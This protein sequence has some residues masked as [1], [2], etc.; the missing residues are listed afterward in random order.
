VTAADPAGTR[1]VPPSQEL[2]SGVDALVRLLVLRQELDQRDGLTTATMV[3][4]Y[5]GSP[6]G[7]LDLALEQA[8]AS[9]GAHRI[10]H[11]PGLNEELAA[12]TVWG[13]QMGEAV[14]YDG[15]DGVVGAWYGKTPGLDRSGDVMKHA[16]AMGA[17]PNGGVV[18]L[19]G[20][21]PTAKSSTLPCD[22]Q[23]TFQDAAMPVLYPGNPQEVVDL[24]IH[25]FRL[26]RY[27]G[28]WVGLKVVTAVADGIGTVDLD[29]DR[30]G[31]PALPEVRIGGSVWRHAPQRTLGPH[32]VAGQEALVHEHRLAAAEAYVVHNG[33][34]RVVGA[35]PGA[36]LGIVAAGKTAHD[37]RQA[38]ADLGVGHDGLEAAGIRV[39][40][41]AM[42]YPVAT[43]TVLDFAATVD[44]LLVVEEKRPF[45]ETQLRS[46]LHEAGRTVPVRGKRDGAGQPLVSSV[47][48]LVPAAIATVIGRV[49]PDLA[50]APVRRTLLPILDL[51]PR[52]PG[53]CS[54]CPHNRSTL[55][56]DG[57]L[58]G[59]G[60]GC[61]GIMYFEARNQGMRSLPPTPMGAE[62][63]PW[64]GLSPFVDEP[65]L[66]QNIGDGTLS[67]SGTLAIRA[68]VAAGVDITFKVLY[69]RAVA[70]TGGQDVT[71]LLDVPSM[72]RALEAEGVAKVVVCAEEPGRYPA[73]ARWAA[74]VEVFGRDHL[75]VVQ[76]QLRSVPGVSVIIYDQRCAAEARR[77][78]S[79]GELDEPP[80]RVLINH[81]VCEGCGD[82]GSKSNC[83]SVLPVATELGEKREIHDASCNRDYTCLDGDCPSF[84]TLRPDPRGRRRAASAAAATARP[85]LPD[86][87]LPA[88]ERP[89]VDPQY[90]IYVTGIG[91]T[92]I[93][94][95]NRIVATAAELG[96]LSIGGMDQTGLSQKAGAV[97]SHLHLAADPAHLGSAVVSDGGADLYLS[98]DILQAAG[99]QH[100]DKVEAG[101]TIAVVDPEVTPTAAMLQTGAPPLDVGALR[102]RIAERVG[103]DRVV[104]VD[105]KALSERVF[106]QPL[107]ANIILLGAAYQAGALPLSLE[108]VDRAMRERGR[109]YDTTRE[110]FDWGRWVVHDRDAVD[111]R[112]GAAGSAA[113]ATSILDPS[114]AAVEQAARLVRGRRLPE[115]LCPLLL[116][117][118]AQVV[119]YQSPA[120]GRRFLDLVDLAASVDDAGHDWAFT[121]TVAESWFQVLTYKD[122]YEVARL[123]RKVD[124]ERAAADL[125]IEGPFSVTYHLHP[126]V[127]RRLGIT[128]KLPL[129][130]P[131]EAMFRVLQRGKRLRGT[132]LDPFGWDRDRKM[133]RSV[134]VEVEALVRRLCG[135]D[136]D[137]AY[138]E[139]LHL[140]A[141]VAEIRGYAQ[142]KERA[143]ERWRAEV[144]RATAGSGNDGV[145]PPTAVRH[146]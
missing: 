28:A 114:V 105:S 142:I 84:V 124:Y 15:V 93:V 135:P 72:T 140:V 41:L 47:G 64:I 141:S 81:A 2:L 63:V 35:P 32:A 70:M 38:L 50:P 91:G 92:G 103:A 111:R 23:L 138:A 126:P 101:R 20:D 67:H 96:G 40:T 60:V 6:L 65:H 76:E 36:R 128:K 48:E 27:C 69:N 52:P 116:R 80:R 66:I 55:V 56:P 37:V 115:P 31:P 102:A 86:G 49:L 77:L 53:Y 107:L 24:G 75:P 137:L 45:V 18:M 130:R 39:L 127:L 117:R 90:G 113:A 4:G 3:S 85:R 145:V 129:G 22:S 54:G 59:G 143:V 134:I 87:L 97:V 14:A 9:L 13:S 10:V 79:R 100:L 11:R 133:E 25:A 123:H 19:C 62:G 125:G 99:E 112:L 121:R 108:L 58:V 8:A 106:A 30:H 57:A 119:D 82:C 144:A 21:D 89:A 61:H 44:E 139:R 104:F 68:S 78:R 88:P 74:G 42:T 71:G 131:Y 118:T 7:T 1:S 29:H 132:A 146:P 73:R 26:S 94:T 120:L 16:N 98:G 109:G 136:A 12:A 5:P 83:L 122:E 46:I 34:D 43:A 33:L 95:A 110:A 17:G 51:P